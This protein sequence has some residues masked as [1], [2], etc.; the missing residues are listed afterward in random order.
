M[1]Y[2]LWIPPKTSRLRMPFQI[3]PVTHVIVMRQHYI[4]LSFLVFVFI[5]IL[6]LAALILLAV[7]LTH[8]IRASYQWSVKDFSV[9]WKYCYCE[10]IACAF[11]F[12]GFNRQLSAAGLWPVRFR[13]FSKVFSIAILPVTC[14]NNLLPMGCL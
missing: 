11:N 1:Y 4:K 8:R 3:F 14:S 6:R 7:L 13:F 5:F 2:L 10:I 9:C 12:S